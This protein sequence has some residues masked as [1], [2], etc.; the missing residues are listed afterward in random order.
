MEDTKN[1]T[2]YRDFERRLLEVLDKNNG[3][4]SEEEDLLLAEAD[5]IWYS[6]TG[7]EEAWIRDND[8]PYFNAIRK[9]RTK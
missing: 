1:I 9:W 3:D 8:G 6:M 4:D 5:V 2:A 7:K